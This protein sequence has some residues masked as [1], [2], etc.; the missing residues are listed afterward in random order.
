MLFSRWEHVIYLYHGMTGRR[1]VTR[2]FVMAAMILTSSITHA[3]TRSIG[4]IFSYTGLS[5][6][7]EIPVET[8]SASRESFIDLELK[9]EN[10][11]LYTGRHSYPGVSAAASW[12]FIL[13]EWKSPDGNTVNFFAGPGVAL[14]YCADY[15]TDNGVMFGFKGRVGVECHFKRNVIISATFAPIIGSHITDYNGFALMKYYR[16][17]L[18]YALIPE[19]GIKYRF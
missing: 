7:I 17:G 11:E 10:E 6:S 14:G 4:A 18:Q 19:I 9:A 13:K 3:R 16:N 12:N 5:T 1:F 15:K 2:I 8:K